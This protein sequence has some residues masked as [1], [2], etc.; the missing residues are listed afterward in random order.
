MKCD[1]DKVQLKQ[2]KLL[3]GSS[4]LKNETRRHVSRKMT[5]DRRVADGQSELKYETILDKRRINALKIRWLLYE[6][7]P[8]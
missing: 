6:E 8:E 1:F 4:N 5:Q 3:V 7:Y 2:L